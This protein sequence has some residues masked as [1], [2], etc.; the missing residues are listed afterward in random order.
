[1]NMPAVENRPHILAGIERWS[2]LP[3]DEQRV[4][5]AWAAGLFDG[6]GSIGENH[7]DKR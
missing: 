7:S 2:A 1:M 4:R 3:E 6:E 5:I